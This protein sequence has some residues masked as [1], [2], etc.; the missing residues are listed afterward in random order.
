[1]SQERHRRIF[2]AYCS[3]KEATVGRSHLELLQVHGILEAATHRNGKAMPAV[4]AGGGGGVDQVPHR[5][6]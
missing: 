4:E 1:M 3:A 6:S 5:G 2:N